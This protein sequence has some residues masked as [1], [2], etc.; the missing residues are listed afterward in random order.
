MRRASWVLTIASL[1]ACVGCGGGG[2]SSVPTTSSLSSVTVAPD[3]ASVVAGS[4][5][6]L[7]A[8]GHYT[9]GSTKDISTSATWTSS[10]AG[11]A[12]VTSTGLTTGVSP[13]SASISAAFGGTSGGVTL[14]VEAP[15]SSVTVGPDPATVAAGFVRQLTATGHYSDGSTKDIST[16]ATWTS[17]NAGVAT[18][19]NTGLTTG[20][21]PGSASIS[22]ALGG[23]SGGVTLTVDAPPAFDGQVNAIA[24]GSDGTIYLGG[25][26]TSV[27]PATGSWVPID[28]VTGQNAVSFA[29]TNGG[30]YAAAPD[31]SGGWFIGGSFT[32]VGGIPRNNVAHVKS[33]GAVD[34]AWDPNANDVVRALAV[35]GSTVYAGGYFTSVGPNPAGTFAALSR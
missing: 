11:V 14:T 18:V 24:T 34:D 21:S 26:F 5:L 13:G 7:T 35:S 16:S 17:S 6:Q 33:D 19:T 27:G 15:P 10:N 4:V 3:P 31:G 2:G 30:V 9:D 1:A 12:T 8:T 32:Y 23:I 29:R 22:A 20:V 25:D 28:A